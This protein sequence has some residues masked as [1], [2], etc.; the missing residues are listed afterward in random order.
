MQ[1]S[2][3]AGGRDLETVHFE[4]VIKSGAQIGFVQEE[5]CQ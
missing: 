5:G 2:I 4:E 3:W 1:L